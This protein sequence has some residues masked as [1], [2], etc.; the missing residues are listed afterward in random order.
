MGRK[1]ARRYE[2]SGLG[3]VA[4]ALLAL[5]GAVIWLAS[6]VVDLKR[7]DISVTDEPLQYWTLVVVMLGIAA[8][9]GWTGVRIVLGL[10]APYGG[11]K[12]QR[13]K[14]PP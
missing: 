2:W 3:L 6:G 8:W 9:L 13:K 11:S 4:M 7:S 10:Q 5:T 1:V 14:R 12:A